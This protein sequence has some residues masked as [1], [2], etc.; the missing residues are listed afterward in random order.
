VLAPNEFYEPSMMPP[1]RNTSLLNIQS[2]SS[3]MMC[4]NC[5]QCRTDIQGS[6]VQRSG[7]R[8]QNSR[9]RSPRIPPNRS[10]ASAN[11][12]S[13][14]DLPLQRTS[15]RFSTHRSGSSNSQL[16]DTDNVM[17]YK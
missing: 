14:L 3:R 2:H 12:P 13:L 16:H 6:C 11:I 7:Y 8:R 5:P 9:S 15:N 17:N 1:I 4:L 10:V